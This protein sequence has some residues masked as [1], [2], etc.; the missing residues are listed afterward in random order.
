MQHLEHK[1]IKVAIFGQ[2]LPG[3][4]GGIETNLLKLVNSLADHNGNGDQQVIIGPGGATDWLHPYLGQG[5]S[6]LAWPPLRYD[7]Y[8]PSQT[9]L[10]RFT[11]A[12]DTKTF[13]HLLLGNMRAN[14]QPQKLDNSLKSLGV[15][16]LHFPYQRYFQTT[17]PFVFEPW[18]LQHIHLPELFTQTEIDFRNKLYRQACEEASIVV[19]ATKWTKKDL[20]DNFGLPAS[21]IAV[22]PRGASQPK[23]LAAQ[24]DIEKTLSKFNLPADFIIYPAK[25]W[26]HKNHTRLFK[27]LSIL[28]TRFNIVIPLVCTGKPIKSSLNEISDEMLS[29]GLANQVYFTDFISEEELKHLYM[30]SRCM[31]FPSLFEGLGI[32]LLEAFEYG[33]PVAC[34]NASCLTEIGGDAAIY[35]DPY[36]T[37]DMADKIRMLWTDNALREKLAANIE[38]KLN[39]FNW[40]KSAHLFKLVYKFLAKKQL[41]S[42]EQSELA[43]ILA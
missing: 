30:A 8:Y 35:F 41:S 21:K 34:S 22:I 33:V 43:A 4:A 2:L 25:T 11:S 7:K 13:I 29:L 40:N 39:C 3:S 9:L 5:Q 16:V 17:L 24:I 15:E 27:A 14:K 10:K 19:T 32:P 31:V 20:I 6:A 38:G 1:N 26:P 36:S 12:K 28:N 23:T 42:I 18:D 37:E